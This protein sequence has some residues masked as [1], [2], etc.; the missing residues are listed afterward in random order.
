MAAMR[1]EYGSNTKATQVAVQ[2]G[3]YLPQQGLNRNHVYSFLLSAKA[4]GGTIC[5]QTAAT[6]GKISNRCRI[7]YVMDQ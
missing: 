6:A 5:I 7:N 1:M 4:T 2:G 3:G